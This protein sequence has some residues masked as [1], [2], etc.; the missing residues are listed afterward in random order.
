MMFDGLRSPW[1]TPRACACASPA[2]TWST[3]AQMTLHG[4]CVVCIHSWTLRPGRTSMTKNGLPSASCPKSRARTIAGWSSSATA[5][6]SWWNHQ[7]SS[8]ARLALLGRAQALERD[9]VARDDVAAEVDDAHAAA[10]ELAHDLVALREDGPD[11]ARRG[12][13]ALLL[14][15]GRHGAARRQPQLSVLR[16]GVRLSRASVRPAAACASRR[17]SPRMRRSA[18]RS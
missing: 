17:R 18:A 2:S 8:G 1:M 3:I 9:A 6:A 11:L 7:L 13:R 14:P 15:C 12:A 16:A 5:R 4:R 10:A